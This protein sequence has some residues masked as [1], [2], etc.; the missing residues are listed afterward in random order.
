MNDKQFQK[1]LDKAVKSAM[2]HRAL[3]EQVGKECIERYG[4]HYSDIDVDV[5]VDC[6]IDAVDH[7][8]GFI[9]VDEITKEFK[10]VMD[11]HNLNKDDEPV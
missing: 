7:G 10:T 3:M 1:L 5:D 4:Y 11:I 6:V 9:T 8:I 2:Q